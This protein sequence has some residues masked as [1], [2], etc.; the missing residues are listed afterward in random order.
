MTVDQ[1][2]ASPMVRDEL[3]DVVVMLCARFPERRTADIEWLV[4]D[5]Y[6]TLS[7]NARI[8]AHLIPLTLN[9]CRR[10]LNDHSPILLNH[11]ALDH[12]LVVGA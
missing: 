11:R 6:Q 2:V 8:Q 1:T 10:L 7:D 5:A 12:A 3:E 9:R 4:T